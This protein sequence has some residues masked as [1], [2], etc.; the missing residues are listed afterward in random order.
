MTDARFRDGPTWSVSSR[1]RSSWGNRFFIDTEF[2]DFEAPQLISLAIVGENGS[3]FYGECSDYDASRCSDF[4]GAVVLPQLGRFKGRAMEFDQLRQTLR[5][6]IAAIPAASKPVLCYDLQIDLDLLRFQLGGPLPKGW[7]L[8]DIRSQ[9]DARRKA[10]Y[11]AR[12]GGE[13]HALQ[14]ARAN[15]YAY[16]G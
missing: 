12:H 9:I 10:E 14:D 3:E 7:A 13:H 15:A 16:I 11:F 8:A 4:V 6:W 5:V 2:T 1:G